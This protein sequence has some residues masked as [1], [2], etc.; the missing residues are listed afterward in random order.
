VNLKVEKEE[1]EKKIL[2]E[3]MIAANQIYD[4][5]CII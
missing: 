3:S 4:T 1:I 5:K 2:K